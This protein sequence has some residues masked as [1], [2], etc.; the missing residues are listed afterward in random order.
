M[1]IIHSSLQFM[2]TT[3]NSSALITAYMLKSPL[4]PKLYY[5]KKKKMQQYTHFRQARAKTSK[6]AKK[7]RRKSKPFFATH[8]F[9]SSPSKKEQEEKEILRNCPLPL[10]QR[11]KKNTRKLK[12]NSE[13]K[14]IYHNMA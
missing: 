6:D 8:P 11:K 12:R 10:H 7:R 13:K 2:H 14:K 9:T 3:P 5:K 1:L 4:T